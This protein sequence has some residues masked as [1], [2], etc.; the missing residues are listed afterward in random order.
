MNKQLSFF[1]SLVVSLL[2]FSCS[3]DETTATVE[4]ETAK[5]VV[6]TYTLSSIST[7]SGSAVSGVTGSAVLTQNTNATVS[8][9]TALIFKTASSSSS[10]TITLDYT[11]VKNG[12]NYDVYDSSNTKQGTVVGSKLTLYVTNFG[13]GITYT[14]VF[15]K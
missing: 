1:L 5:Y 9:K 13:S 12:S 11:I 2:M 3:K 6:G 7:T 15:I 10:S 14:G 8:L 4:P